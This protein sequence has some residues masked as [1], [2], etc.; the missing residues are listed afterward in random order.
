MSTA[1]VPFRQVAN[2]IDL[3]TVRDKFSNIIQG[4]EDAIDSEVQR[5]VAD[6][7]VPSSRDAF[8]KWM[9][10]LDEEVANKVAVILLRSEKRNILRSRKR[11]SSFIEDSEFS[12]VDK[13]ADDLFLNQVAYYDS[14]F[15]FSNMSQTVYS[16]DMDDGLK[17]I[18][19]QSENKQEAQKQFREYAE[20]QLPK[21]YVEAAGEI[22]NP[23]IG[24]MERSPKPRILNFEDTNQL[25]IEYWSLGTETEIYH[26][27]RGETLEFRG[28]VRSQV[29]IYI[30]SELVEYASTR[31]AQ[32]QQIKIENHVSDVFDFEQQTATDGG[33][34]KETADDEPNLLTRYKNN[35]DSSDISDVINN[36]GI[37]STLETFQSQNATIRYSSV[38]KRDVSEG[39]NHDDIENDTKYRR[40]NVQI[41]IEDP[42][43]KCRYISPDEVNRNFT[44]PKDASMRDIKETM[45]EDNYQN[46]SSIPISLNS[47]NNTVL[48]DRENYSPS[49]RKTVFNLVTDQLGW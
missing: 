42:A 34:S 1:D 37:I 25:F 41:L 22:P 15:K 23:L 16:V 31:K 13:I 28:R 33:Q 8:Y 2:V 27:Q 4:K 18:S 9:N 11:K 39:P 29:R 6:L 48:F 36:I 32:G 40:A 7:G 44:F 43:G 14:F 30:D 20:D 3:G 10:Q 46:L 17:R 47:K 5:S 38:N 24:Q 26:P 19:D 35:I 21:E 49:T 12:D 45:H